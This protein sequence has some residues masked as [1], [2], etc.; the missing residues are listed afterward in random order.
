MA[1]RVE[2]RCE[3][4]GGEGPETERAQL[5]RNKRA[6]VWFRLTFALPHADG[7]VLEAPAPS[8]LWEL[9]SGL[10]QLAACAPLV[11]RADFTTT[12]NRICLR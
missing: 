7:S 11:I 9:Q 10:L 6:A 1:P 3:R 8:A 4:F 5:S 2:V 12:P